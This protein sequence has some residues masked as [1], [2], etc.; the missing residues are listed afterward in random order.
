M[1]IGVGCHFFLQGILH[2]GI[3]AASPTLA[4]GFF[5]AEMA[6]A[7]PVALVVKNLLANAGDIRDTSSIPALRRSPEEGSS[8]PLQ[9]FFLENPKDRGAWSTTVHAWGH[10]ESDTT[11]VT[12]RKCTPGDTLWI[13]HMSPDAMLFLRTSLFN[14]VATIPNGYLDLYLNNLILNK[15]NI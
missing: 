1:N 14:T 2:S 8:N 5:T 3:K 12:E 13:T 11:E 4:G 6:G 15:I 7:S 10:K 9:Y